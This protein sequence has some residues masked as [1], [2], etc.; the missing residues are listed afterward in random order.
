MRGGS[1]LFENGGQEGVK[2]EGVKREGG[3]RKGRQEL[4]FELRFC[5]TFLKEGQGFRYFYL[6]LYFSIFPCFLR[7]II[8]VG[9]I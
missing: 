6:H 7:E 4:R 8:T 5:C 3:R 9:D 1:R 2:R